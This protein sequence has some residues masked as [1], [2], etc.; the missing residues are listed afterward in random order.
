MFP[1]HIKYISPF[2]SSRFINL[3]RYT[4]KNSTIFVPSLLIISL[5]TYLS[6]DKRNVVLAPGINLPILEKMNSKN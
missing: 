6:L 4:Y 1:N 2:S 5:S 3:K